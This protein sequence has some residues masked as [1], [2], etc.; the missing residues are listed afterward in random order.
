[1]KNVSAALAGTPPGIALLSHSHPPPRLS[2]WGPAWAST[3]AVWLCVGPG[4]PA[5]WLALPV[6]W[7]RRTCGTM[8][9]LVSPGSRDPL[10]KDARGRLWDR[11]EFL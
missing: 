3:G 7:G 1:M 5:A 4:S 2:S 9:S 6:G 11:V 10:L 8:A